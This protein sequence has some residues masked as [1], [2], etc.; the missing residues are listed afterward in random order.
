MQRLRLYELG[1]RLWMGC[2]IGMLWHPGS[3]MI[4]IATP[5]HRHRSKPFW[6]SQPC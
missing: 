1:L 6:R 2:Q 3:P 4:A 5:I